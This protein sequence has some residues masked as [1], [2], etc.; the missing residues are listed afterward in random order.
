[1]E[2]KRAVAMEVEKVVV[3]IIEYEENDRANLAL[4]TDECGFG[5]FAGRVHVQRAELPHLQLTDLSVGRV[6]GDVS[7]AC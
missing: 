4:D 6:W 1:M 2:A 7:L 3:V 5:R